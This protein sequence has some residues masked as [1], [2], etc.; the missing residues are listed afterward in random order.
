MN[1]FNNEHR[2]FT[3]LQKLDAF[4]LMLFSY[5]FASYTSANFTPGASPRLHALL[6]LLSPPSTFFFRLFATV[7]NIVIREILL[8]ATTRLS[9]A[10]LHGYKE[11]YSD[12]I[13]LLLRAQF[14]CLAL[15]DLYHL[16]KKAVSIKKHL[17][18]NRKDKDSK[19]KLILVES[20]I[21][22]L[23][24]YYKKTNKLPPVWK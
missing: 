12:F 15:E 17:E 5:P 20:R 6:L 18:R 21:Y 24:R 3:F 8:G 1:Q 22:R 2:G 4:L 14:F 16:I 11:V 19:F 23:A 13:I 10:T 7:S 9:R